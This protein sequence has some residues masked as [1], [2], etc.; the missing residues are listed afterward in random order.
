MIRFLKIIF[1]FFVFI[2][3]AN[4][5]NCNL[6][7]ERESEND[8]SQNNFLKS[9]HAYIFFDNSLNMKGFVNKDNSNSSEINYN[10][11]ELINKLPLA[12]PTISKKQSF[13]SFSKT[14][15][16]IGTENVTNATQT[17][18]YECNEPGTECIKNKSKISKILNV[19]TKEGSDESNLY[20]LV[21]DLVLKQDE[22]IGKEIEKIRSSFKQSLDGGKSIGIF[23]IKSKFN[24]NIWGL[25]NGTKYNQ[26]LER[27]FFVIMIGDQEVILKLKKILEADLF[28]EIKEED[29]HFSL[30]TN[31][32]I[33]NPITNNNFSKKNFI[34][35][36][37]IQSS[38]FYDESTDISQFNF[39]KK[40]DPLAISLNLADI[41]TPYSSLLDKFIVRTNI[42]NIDK[43]KDFKF[44]DTESQEKFII[45]DNY[46]DNKINFKF[47]NRANKD[48]NLLP[49]G[50]SYI[51]QA[52]IFSQAISDESGTWFKEWSFSKPELDELISTGKDFFPVLNLSNFGNLLSEIQ[53]E[54]FTEQFLGSFQFAINLK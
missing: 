15:K 29:Y 18:F 3:I 19:I 30:F 47:L 41:Q 31:D 10:Y 37:G 22:L 34:T 13:Q 16:T 38:S 5:N 32:L 33:A 49:R 25:P 35:T 24:G 40:H 12:I 54:R 6:F 1:I 44:K 27:P 28:N 46:T 50:R 36:K 14:I 53:K 20:I 11:L 21:T 17:S 4:S 2:P 23:G 52:D 48:S 9:E 43:C 39:D 42:K 8:N 45:F 7:D 51:L 26:A